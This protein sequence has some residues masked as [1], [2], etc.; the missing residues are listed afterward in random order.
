MVSH[1]T[2]TLIAY[3]LGIGL[4]H[5]ITNNLHYMCD[6]M[7]PIFFLNENSKCFTV[8]YLFWKWYIN[9]L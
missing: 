1:T 5:S 4:V 7:C 2:T 3:L 9:Q 8:L 6:Y